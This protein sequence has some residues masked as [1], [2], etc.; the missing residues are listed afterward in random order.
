MSVGARIKKLRQNNKLSVR[1]LAKQVHLSASFVY[2]LEQDKVSPSFA[3]LKN[4]AKALDTSITLLIEDK[5]PEE[6]VIVREAGRKRVVTENE[7]LKL[8]LLTFLGSREKNMQPMIF[9]LE[10]G[11]ESSENF[12]THERE[13][14]IFLLSGEVEVAVGKNKYLLK[15]GDAGYFIFDSPAT[16]K[17]TGAEKAKGLWICSPPY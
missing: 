11:A 8:Q 9:E 3:T 5:L 10:P 4:I 6:W 14:F 2:Q 1:E 13:D 7:N 17:S 16:I 12:F 15:E